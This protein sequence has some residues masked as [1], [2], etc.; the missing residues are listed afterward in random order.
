MTCVGH[1][2]R[3]ENELKLWEDIDQVIVKEQ[4]KRGNNGNNLDSK[5][6]CPF[7][8]AA[9]A[10]KAD[11]EELTRRTPLHYKNQRNLIALTK[12]DPN[13]AQYGFIPAEIEGALVELGVQKQHKANVAK[14]IALLIHEHIAKC[15]RER[16]DIIAKERQLNATWRF[17]V[18][19][20][21]WP[22]ANK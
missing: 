19:G 2:T 3:R 16:C 13:A 12:I 20:I 15:H 21:P 10:S 18:M 6:F 8:H 4:H 9:N 1:P 14:T 22:D 17:H 7:A 5:F 11:Y